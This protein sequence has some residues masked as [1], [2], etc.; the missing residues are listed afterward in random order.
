MSLGAV[1]KTR[2][3]LDGPGS[4][5]LGAREGED[6]TVGK[7][8]VPRSRPTR[9]RVHSLPRISAPALVSPLIARIIILV[10]I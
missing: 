5:L 4:A 2:R 7:R 3:Q 1:A 10:V 8:R 9:S 6:G